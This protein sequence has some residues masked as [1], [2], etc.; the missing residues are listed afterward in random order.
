[1]VPKT[2]EKLI[3]RMPELVEQIIQKRGGYID[4][5]KI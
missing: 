4:E 1:M 3:K 2:I 5:K